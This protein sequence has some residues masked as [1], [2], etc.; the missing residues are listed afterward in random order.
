MET[1]VTCTVNYR[2]KHS[3]LSLHLCKE[4]ITAV[5]VQALFL[6]EIKYLTF[7]S[8]SIKFNTL[9]NE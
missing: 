7:Y 3:I 2:F 1:G 6:L 4:Y 9:E 5:K 8:A